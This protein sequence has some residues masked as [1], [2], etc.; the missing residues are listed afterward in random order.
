MA[1][2]TLPGDSLPPWVSG[3][4]N[5]RKYKNRVVEYHKHTEGSLVCIELLSNVEV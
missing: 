5:A 3:L 1:V 2:I 4:F